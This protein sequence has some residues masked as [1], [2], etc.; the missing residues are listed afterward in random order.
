MKT[1]DKFEVNYYGWLGWRY[2]ANLTTRESV[3][4]NIDRA[5]NPKQAAQQANEGWEHCETGLYY[6]KYRCIK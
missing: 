1:N 5:D 6:E 2:R 3:K 4:M